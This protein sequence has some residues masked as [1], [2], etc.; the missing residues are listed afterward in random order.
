MPMPIVS[1]AQMREWEKLTWGTGQ[2][3]AAVI[4]RVGQ[5]LAQRV[6]ALTHPNDLVLLLAGKGH[7][8]DDVRAVQPHL[9]GRRIDLVEVT[10]P[11]KAY[12]QLE[13]C[14]GRNPA[15]VIDGLF[16][17]GLNGPLD[18][19]WIR[20]IQRLN[21][22][23]CRVMAVDIPSGLDAETGRNHGVAVEAAI[24][25]TIGAPKIG[26]LNDT[27]WASTGRMEVL[28][29]VGLTTCPFKQD[30]SWSVPEDFTG[31]PTAR[32]V[33]THKG[34]YGH[35]AI[36]AGS[37]G[38][39]GA[40]V[41]AARGAQRAQPGLITLHT[42]EAV[43]PVVA[44]HLQAVM[45][46]PW[47][48]DTKL[49]G[50]WTAIL[51]GPGLAASDLPDQM[52]LQ[53]RLLWRDSALPLIVDA[54]ALDWL[55]LDITPR[56]AIRVLTPHPGEAARLMRTTTEKVQSNRVAAVRDISRRYANAWVVLKSHQTVI[57]RS[58]G[59]VFVNSSGNPHMAQGGSGD[60]LS[61][62]LAGLLA[63]PALQNDV[64]TTLRYA[65]WQHG[66]AA[67]RLQLKQP[68]WIV[69]DL[70]REIGLPT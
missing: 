13:I 22:S 21:Q 17:I 11:A 58:E 32:R 65:V 64:L 5:G 57:G 1:V 44:S 49:P 54:S 37:R 12:N 2:T 39:H 52:K 40:A 18:K 19:E 7:N 50:P 28:S 33:G 56:N 10:D 67:D 41:L 25:V 31:F 63:Q 70:L 26:L 69:E 20:F 68:N 35:L 46:A 38:Y 47:R 42:P 8:G 14:L 51:M 53:A 23:G 45:V 60:V 3:Q 24:T 43:Y 36:V 62:F 15:L 6:L 59:E 9:T 30:L 4:H 16:G 48:A 27:A 55:P 66:A 34:T 61:G 29:D